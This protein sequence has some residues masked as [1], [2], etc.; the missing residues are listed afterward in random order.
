MGTGR[1]LLILAG[2]DSSTFFAAV[3]VESSDVNWAGGLSNGPTN[4]TASSYAQGTTTISLASASN[5]KVGNRIILDQLDDTQDIGS[6]LEIGRRLRPSHILR[7]VAR[8]PICYRPP[9]KCIARG[10][11]EMQ[12]TTLT[13]CD[14]STTSWACFLFQGANITDFSRSN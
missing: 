3:C 7:P 13:Q 9:G 11:A 10:A 6:M 12:I 14:G 5:L 4:W 1:T 8:G 2:Q